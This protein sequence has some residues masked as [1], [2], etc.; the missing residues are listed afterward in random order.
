MKNIP[1]S[2]IE[3]SVENFKIF[4]KRVVFSMVGKKSKHTFL[5]NKQNLMKTSLIYGPNASGKSTLLDAFSVLKDGIISSANNINPKYSQ[6]PYYPFLL[7]KD[8]R[9]PIFWEIIFCLE[10]K[11]FKYN[12][13]ISEGEIITENLLQI[14]ST[15]EEKEYLIRKKQN[16]KLFS[17]LKKGGDIKSKTREDVLFLSAAAK[18]NND[19]AIKIINGFRN[20]NIINGADG[21]DYGGFTIK[22]LSNPINKKK[23]LDYLKRADFLIDD[24]KIKEIEIPESII[25]KIALIDKKNIAKTMYSVSVY[26]SKFDDN[27]KNIGSEEFNIENESEGTQTFF[28]LIGPIIDTLA[29]GKVLLIDEFDN[30]I[31]PLLTKFIIDLFVNNNDNGA[32]LIVTT[33]DTSLLS[34][35]K[36]FIKDQ[37]WF[38]EKDKFGVGSLF[39]LAEFDNLR[40]DTQFFKKYIEGKFGALPFIK[41][42]NINDEN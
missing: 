7:S 4:K 17:G 3:F 1:I 42:I 2:V 25:K 20:I 33:H 40:N 14:L 30:S 23:V 6:L 5:S 34:Y 10:E 29:N 21:G 15:G 36:E 9:K 41:S 31:H 19:L 26:H 12:F 16:I 28:N 8:N 11:I 35:N 27:G 24:I 38:T 18:W 39:S 32:Q 13:S 37:I 22:F